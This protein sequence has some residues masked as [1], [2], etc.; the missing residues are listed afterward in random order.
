M[1]VAC[2]AVRHSASEDPPPRPHNL[3][4]RDCLGDTTA[5][6]KASLSLC[7]RPPFQ[8]H[9]LSL[10]TSNETEISSTNCFVMQCTPLLFMDTIQDDH[11]S[12]QMH[13]QTNER[14]KKQINNQHKMKKNK[15]KPN[16]KKHRQK[17]KLKSKASNSVITTYISNLISKFDNFSTCLNIYTCAMYWL[18][19]TLFYIDSILTVAARC[20]AS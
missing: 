19:Q 3:A 4:L 8:L 6:N 2:R 17:Q 18:E 20:N 5:E 9:E 14:T 16:R 11:K 15:N 1:G 7:S 12:K 13:K 10:V